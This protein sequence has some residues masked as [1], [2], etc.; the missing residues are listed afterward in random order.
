MAQDRSVLDLAMEDMARLQKRLGV[1][2]R[3]TVDE[4]LTAVR[5]VEQRIQRAENHIDSNVPVPE[6]PVG[7]PDNFDD[8]AKLMLDLTFLAYQADVTRV[9]A[10]QFSRELSGR[11]YPWIGVPD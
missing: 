6:Q 8:H 2:D 9:V 4:Y 1:R 3:I 10:F 7:V 5:D 11:A